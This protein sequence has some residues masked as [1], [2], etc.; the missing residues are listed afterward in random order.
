MKTQHDTWVVLFALVAASVSGMSGACAIIA[1]KFLRGKKVDHMAFAAYAMI[2][3]F[4]SAVL[5]GFYLLQGWVDPSLE[6]AVVYGG[7][8]GFLATLVI[9]CVNWGSRIVLKYRGLEA[10]ITFKDTRKQPQE[11]HHE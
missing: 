11:D 2:G 6:E 7:S 1:S 8:S 3:M 9:V 4:T 5:F 10:E